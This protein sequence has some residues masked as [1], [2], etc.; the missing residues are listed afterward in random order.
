MFLALTLLPMLA[1]LGY[2]LLYSL[3]LVGAL[4]QG[5]TLQHWQQLLGQWP[6]WASLLWSMGIATLALAL[7]WLA[8]L[9]TLHLLGDA[10]QR[11][12]VQALLHIPLALPPMIAAFIGFQW[13]GSAGLLS[14][15]A[16]RLGLV[17]S[18]QAFPVLINDSYYLGVIVLL[19]AMSYPFFLLLMLDYYRNGGVAAYIDLAR[20][21]GASSWQSSAKVLL[22]LMWHKTKAN[23]ILV[24]IVA[25]GAFEVPLLL[26]QQ[27]PAM[28][29]V[30]IHQKFRKFN[31]DDYP[32]AYA[33]TVLYALIALLFVLLL[34]RQNKE[35]KWA[36]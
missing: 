32:Q 13:L 15:V 33:A 8:A 7:A 27:S 26:G 34:T 21:L 23:A 20:T 17:D 12:W 24:F 11:G 5:F 36:D 22:P 35:E 25:F 10:L 2:A 14:R 30:F 31:L 6:F 16:Y 18:I 1:S 9:A 29:S 4:A 28:I 19:A 3:G